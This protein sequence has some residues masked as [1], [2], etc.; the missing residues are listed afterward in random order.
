MIHEGM[1]R[2]ELA[3]AIHRSIPTV[4]RLL[5]YLEHEGKII[6]RGSK[7]T[8]GYYAIQPQGKA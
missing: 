2:D 8:G 5:A 7:K 1:K 6:Y 4:A 3:A